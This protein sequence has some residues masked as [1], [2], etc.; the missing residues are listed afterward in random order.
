MELVGVGPLLVTAA[1]H[2]Q[3]RPKSART[4]ASRASCSVV[5][6]GESFASFTPLA[7][8]PERGVDSPVF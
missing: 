1:K 8:V 3:Q 5:R 2:R 7:E 4:L 6:V